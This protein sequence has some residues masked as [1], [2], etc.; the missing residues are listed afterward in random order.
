VNQ[1][2]SLRSV[3]DSSELI[4]GHSDMRM[5]PN[6]TCTGPEFALLA[7]AGERDR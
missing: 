6:N 7:P 3:A 4:V 1:L 5:P 2:S